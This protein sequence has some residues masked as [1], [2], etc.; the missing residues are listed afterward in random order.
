MMFRP[1]NQGSWNRV[2][3]FSAKDEPTRRPRRCKDGDTHSTLTGRPA[4]STSSSSELQ[5]GLVRLRILFWGLESRKAALQG[6]FP[7]SG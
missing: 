4:R 5:S 7:N 6:R 3:P 1:R 2:E